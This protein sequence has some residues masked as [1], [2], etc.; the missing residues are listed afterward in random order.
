MADAAGYEREE[1]TVHIHPL[2]DPA[3]H[4]TGYVVDCLRS[5]RL[6]VHG[7]TFEDVVKRAVMLGN[8]TDTTAAVAGGIAGLMFG[9]EATPGR[10]RSRL[11]GMDIV[12][13]LLARLTASA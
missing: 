2:D 5:A 1:A 12:E 4:G 13:P 11:R 3:G 10:W 9:A 6:A 8:D 7:E